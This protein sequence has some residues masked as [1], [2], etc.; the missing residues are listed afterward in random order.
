MKANIQDRSEFSAHEWITDKLGVP[1]FFT[2]A[3]SSWQKGAVGYISYSNRTK[4]LF[5]RH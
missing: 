1:V 5:Y 4:L 2:D 3:Y